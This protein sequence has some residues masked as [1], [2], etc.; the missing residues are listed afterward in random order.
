[1]PGGKDILVLDKVAIDANKAV[2]DWSDITVYSMLLVLKLY[3]PNGTG[4]V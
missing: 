2:G 1:M 3:Y 4:K